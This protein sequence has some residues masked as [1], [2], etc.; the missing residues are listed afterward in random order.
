MPVVAVGMMQED[1]THSYGKQNSDSERESTQIP[2]PKSLPKGIHSG[3]GV[4][5]VTAAE[6]LCPWLESS[7]PRMSS[8]L[9]SSWGCS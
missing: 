5:T 9:L 3:K 7:N 6:K 8:L 1:A 4:G 2:V